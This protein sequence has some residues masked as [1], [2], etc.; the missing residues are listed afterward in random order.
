MTNDFM[1]SEE[2][3]DGDC[4][5]SSNGSHSVSRV[6]CTRPLSYKSEKVDSFF[7]KLATLTN[8]QKSTSVGARL[9]IPRRIG[10]TSERTL[11]DGQ[12][13]CMGY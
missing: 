11:P 5:D 7:K 4:E 8:Q 6:L 10:S 12:L 2:S 1:S 9:Y 3:E 13:P